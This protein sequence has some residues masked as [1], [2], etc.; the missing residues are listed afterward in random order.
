MN[1]IGFQN[2]RRFA[3]FPELEY[4]GITLLVGKNNSGKSTV[5]KAFLLIGDFLKSKNVRTFSFGSNMFEDANIVT[6]ERALNVNAK[7][8]NEDFIRF[9]YQFNEFIIDIE[10]TGEGERTNAD[11]LHFSFTDTSENISF[12]IKPQ[13]STITISKSNKEIDDTEETNKLHEELKEVKSLI[14]NTVLKKSSKEYLELV[15]QY[16][17][18]LEKGEGLVQKWMS[19]EPLVNETVAESNQEYKKRDEFTV[20]SYFTDDMSF[21]EIYNDI[22]AESTS[23][24][25]LARGEDAV[26]EDTVEYDI[27]EIGNYVGFYQNK[28]LVENSFDK[29][30]KFIDK[31]NFKYLGANPAKQSALFAVRDK[32]NAL[33]QAVH[34]YKQLGIDKA[35][36]SEANIFVKKWMGKDNFDIGENMVIN[37]HAG[38]AYEVKINKNGKEIPLADKGMG[39]IQSMLLIL[40]LACVIHKKDMKETTDL[41]FSVSKE[42]HRLFD[43]LN[44]DVVIIEEPELNLHPAFQSKLAEM[45]YEVNIKYGIQLIV[46]THSE[47]LIRKSQVIVAEYELEVSPNTNP[48]TI[49]YFPEEE[50]PYRINYD[51]DGSITPNFGNGFYDESSLRALELMRIKRQKNA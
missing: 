25:F 10:I 11:I 16:N 17:S 27:N 9:H 31:L 51:K 5:V 15:D 45:F 28:A 4:D 34:E 7:S 26:D 43:I 8:R 41:L 46:E 29:F 35:V 38:E 39:S 6:Y 12:V 2:F 24:Y 47:Y 48:F 23:K 44:P 30:N 33:A 19:E 50:A 36:G 21:Q 32:N 40:R 49:Y 1:K 42:M 22:I 37:M 20:S 18:L 14:E 13:L 3:N